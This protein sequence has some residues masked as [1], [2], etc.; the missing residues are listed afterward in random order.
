MSKYSKKL[1]SIHKKDPDLADRIKRAANIKRHR[2]AIERI[3]AA[4]EKLCMELKREPSNKRLSQEAKANMKTVKKALLDL[5]FKIIKS[6]LPRVVGEL[7]HL[8]H[9]YSKTIEPCYSDNQILSMIYRPININK[10]PTT[11]D[12]YNSKVAIQRAF[13]LKVSG[14]KEK[15]EW[16]TDEF[17]EYHKDDEETYR[18]KLRVDGGKTTNN[19][20]LATKSR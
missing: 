13:D 19:Y 4:Y 20:G 18:C 17:G 2:E 12:N 7:E 1:Y 9:S 5:R 6:R 15:P 14:K 11:L 10:T 3:A 16:F 8:E